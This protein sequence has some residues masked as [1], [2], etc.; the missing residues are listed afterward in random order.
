MS[1]EPLAKRFRR[2]FVASVTTCGNEHT[3]TRGGPHLCHRPR[4]HLGVHVDGR[5]RNEYEWPNP[6]GN[7]P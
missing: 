1:D 5:L 3:D 7:A 6:G 2:W 4:W